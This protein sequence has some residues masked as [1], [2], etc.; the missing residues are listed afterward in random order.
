[1]VKMSRFLPGLATGDSSSD[2]RP[3][4]VGGDGGGR[5]NDV[6]LSA[7]GLLER[8]VARGRRRRRG[9]RTKGRRDGENEECQGKNSLATEEENCRGVQ[10]GKMGRGTFLAQS[11]NFSTYSNSSSIRQITSCTSN[12]CTSSL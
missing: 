7:I 9:G 2:L 5:T 1:M 4:D 10:K 8:L 6:Y 3:G 12:R 11:V